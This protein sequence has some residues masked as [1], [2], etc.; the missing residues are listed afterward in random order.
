MSLKIRDSRWQPEVMCDKWDPDSRTFTEVSWL[1]KFG[2]I[3]IWNV[4]PNGLGFT[5]TMSWTYFK[6]KK[7]VDVIGSGNIHRC[8]TKP[9]EATIYSLEAEGEI[10]EKFRATNKTELTLTVEET[11]E[12]RGK[13]RAFFSGNSHKFYQGICD[14]G[15]IHLFLLFSL[16]NI[17]MS[18]LIIDNS[19]SFKVSVT[20]VVNIVYFL[21][22]NH[23]IHPL[24][25][26]LFQM[27]WMRNRTPSNQLGYISFLLI[28]QFFCHDAFLL[29]SNNWDSVAYWTEWNL[30]T[31]EDF[32]GTTLF[33]HRPNYFLFVVQFLGVG[34]LFLWNAGSP[35]QLANCQLTGQVYYL[36]PTSASLRSSAA[37]RTDSDVTR[38]PN[39]SNHGRI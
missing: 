37:I 1:R 19:F 24:S 26:P 12:E 13:N 36:L 29:L 28:V 4:S 10:N 38:S 3:M 17:S 7:L 21:S 15:K 35:C 25:M 14:L 5:L 8:R 39:Q 16:F 33:H 30:L 32:V 34:I 23:W 22:S 20:N 11:S 18:M 9:Y 6:E 31:I 27:P 2:N